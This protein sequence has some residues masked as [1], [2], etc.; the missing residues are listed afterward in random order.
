MKVFIAGLDA[1]DV[2]FGMVGGIITSLI[3]LFSPFGNVPLTFLA[4]LFPSLVLSVIIGRWISGRY[5]L[6]DPLPILAIVMLS[7]MCIGPLWMLYNNDAIMPQTHLNIEHCGMVVILSSMGLIFFLFGNKVMEKTIRFKR[8]WNIS[9][10]KSYVIGT[11][12]LVIGLISSYYFIRSL[13]GFFEMMNIAG[14]RETVTRGYGWLRLLADLFQSSSYFLLFLWINKKR[15]KYTD[16]GIAVIVIII[17]LICTSIVFFRG[18]RLAILINVLWPLYI[19]HVLVNRISIKKMVVLVS[20]LATLFFYYELYKTYGGVAFRTLTHHDIRKDLYSKANITIGKF[21]LLE[22]GR[23]DVDRFIYQEVSMGRQPIICGQ[24]YLQA[25]LQLIPRFL[26]KDRPYGM[27]EILTDMQF[28]KNTF[29]AREN[30]TGVLPTALGEAFLNFWIPGICVSFFFVG[31]FC[32]LARKLLY[33]ANRY[34]IRHFFFVPLLLVVVLLYDASL[35]VAIAN[36]GF[37]L[38]PAL[39]IAFTSSR[40]KARLQ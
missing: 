34:D 19:Y 16:F 3:I 35:Q 25:P 38:A 36:F 2:F 31:V 22:T 27:M 37:Y 30:K 29:A 26:W 14:M 20:M 23:F 28:G 18:S 1:M 40:R 5:D 32:G 10:P 15:K 17:C 24:T 9:W 21:I 12:M 8:K 11:A 7:N 33:D 39:L 6:F 13:G 4:L